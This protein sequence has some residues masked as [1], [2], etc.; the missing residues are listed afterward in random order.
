[1]IQLVLRNASKGEIGWRSAADSAGAVGNQR[2]E[3][4]LIDFYESF[5]C[6]L[7]VTRRTVAYI[8]AEP[9]VLDMRVY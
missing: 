3:L 1:M 7:G 9:A 4:G 2:F 6:A 5:D 8:Q